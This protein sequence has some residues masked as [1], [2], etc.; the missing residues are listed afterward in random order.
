MKLSKQFFLFLYLLSSILFSQ[1]YPWQKPK[2]Y[3]D[4]S[5]NYHGQK[6]SANQLPNVISNKNLIKTIKKV[7]L[8]SHS[9]ID[10]VIATQENGE[11]SRY[12]YSYDSK[13]NITS[14]LTYYFFG[15]YERETYT[16]DDESNLIM[17]L[18]EQKYSKSAQFVNRSR[19]TYTYDSKNNKILELYESWDDSIW[20]FGYR[21]TYTYDSNNNNTAILYENWDGT[22]W[23]PINRYI[24]SYDYR[25][26]MAIELYEDWLDS[27]FVNVER[28]TYTYDSNGNI[29][30]KLKENW[31]VPNWVKYRRQTYTYNSNGNTTSWL[32]EHWRN[33][34]WG[35]D[36]RG[37]FIYDSNGNLSQGFW[38]KWDGTKW[39]LSDRT[40]YTYDS[41]GNMTLWLIEN[42]D[43]ASW[44]LKREWRWTYTYDS[45]GNIT[46]YLSEN[47][48]GT[49]WQLRNDYLQLID[50]FG[51]FLWF[52]G[53]KINLNYKIVTSVKTNE[54]I[55]NYFLSQ[56]YPNPFNP[57]TTIS[58]SI[59]KRSNVSLKV[60]NILG[61][62][63]AVL[64][65]ET[66]NTGNYKRVFDGSN[67]ASGVY[68]YKLQA[69]DF[70]DVKKF[71]L[72]K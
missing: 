13:G 1:Q 18:R 37:T 41:N 15:L 28:E 58:Y 12:K 59:P 61:K 11:E 65:N 68:I 51:N 60:Y 33:S 27:T 22:D 10:S 25:G 3:Y 54:F 52:S 39:I 62:Q 6:T 45:Y 71:V 31:E 44:V 20:V 70:V 16:Y 43:G 42:W 72:M 8:G 49:N 9:V 38:D 35:N 69:G 17:F 50:S 64:V 55:G 30:V 23:E 29:T 32:D 24:Y 21:S 67:L 46:M 36:E 53:A 2:N 7:E 63:V 48:D 4:N 34:K 40:T 57:T 5:V 47:W 26:N 14:N 56:N 66:Q 19:Y